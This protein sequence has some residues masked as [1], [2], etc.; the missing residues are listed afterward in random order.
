MPKGKTGQPRGRPP[1]TA[2][3]SSGLLRL[4]QDAIAI[5]L[6]ACSPEMTAS[7]A[8]RL[9]NR[10]ADPSASV[11]VVVEADRHE[12]IIDWK[13][14]AA[15][16]VINWDRYTQKRLTGSDLS[17]RRGYRPDEAQ[18]VKCCAEC[19]FNMLVAP[20]KFVAQQYAQAL[21]QWE[22]DWPEVV[23]ERLLALAALLHALDA[24]YASIEAGTSRTTAWLEAH[25]GG[26]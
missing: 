9:G 25:D 11:E 8:A 21:A 18:W 24:D 7:N 4:R 12:L 20:H 6:G 15:E 23:L 13:K 1:G 16:Q 5:A 17:L 22:G 14:P 26:I 2:K 10:L 19:C 3:K